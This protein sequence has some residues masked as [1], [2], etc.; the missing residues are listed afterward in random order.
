[1]PGA[2]M[3]RLWRPGAIVPV[4]IVR[5]E[6]AP[7]FVGLM[8]DD[9]NETVPLPAGRGVSTESVT[10]L[11]KAVFL[12]GLLVSSR[13][14]VASPPMVVSKVVTSEVKVKSRVTVPTLTMIGWIFVVRYGLPAWPCTQI[15]KM[16]LLA[17]AGPPSHT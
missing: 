8:L 15:V 2:L 17:P 11:P 7:G 6:W 3:P 12:L 9:E 13:S 1:M 5:V 16:P 10:G 14:N 4:L